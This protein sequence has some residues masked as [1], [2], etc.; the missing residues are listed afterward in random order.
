MRPDRLLVAV[1]AA[2]LLA[3][4]LPAVVPAASHAAETTEP[5][6]PLTVRLVRLTPAAIPAKGR[7]VMSGTVTNVS[8]EQWTAVN[9]HPFISRSPMTSRDQLAAAAASDPANEVGRRL[10]APGQFAAIGDIPPGAT[11]GFR[12]SLKVKDLPITGADG[13]Y[14]IGVHAL[15]QNTTGRDEVADGRART[16]IPLVSKAR[17]GTARTSVSVVVPIRERVR[18]DPDGRVLGLTQW[19]QNLAPSGRL[20]RLAGFLGSATSQQATALVDPAVLAAAKDLSGD[21]PALSFG[22]GKDPSSTPS[23]SATASASRSS[24]RLDPADRANAASWLAQVTASARTHTTLGLGYADPDVTALARRQ[25]S[26]L[27]LA[28]KIAATTFGEFDIPAVPTVAPPDGWLDDDLLTVIPT[29]SMLLVSDHAAPRTRTHWR[30][31]ENQDLVITDQQAASGGPSPGDGLDA[32]SLR[33]RIVSDAALRLSE[34]ADGPMVVELPADYDPGPSWQL[35]D[36]FNRLDLSWLDLVSLNPSSDSTTPTFDAA[37]GY[38]ASARKGE[39]RAPNVNATRTLLST[40]DVLTATLRSKN[41]VAHD[42]SGIAYDAV[43][44]NARNDQLQARS[45]VFATSARMRQT[46]G[47][48]EVIGTDFV[49]LSGGSG[50]LAVT[51]VNGL[52]Q[53]VTVGVKAT[54]PTGDVHIEETE[55]LKLAA[56]ERAVLRLKARASGVGVTPVVLSA[57]TADGTALGTPLTFSL[58]T[59]QVGNL[60]WG[61]LG[62]AALLLVVM[63]GLRIRRGLREHRWRRT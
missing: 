18:R 15:G 40:A 14:W 12:I 1:L 47:R 25:P 50:T 30:T 48:I 62:A 5:S 31:V 54:I 20:G 7:I 43:S 36:F 34:R 24:S 58:R 51:L 42:L 9:V 28:N 17:A 49:T 45:Q 55:P 26:L 60:I 33:Q 53:P 21:N 6:S 32:L 35:A 37:L 27:T 8:T 10:T 3:V 46:L 52:D 44:Y 57:V 19:A 63:I 22:D 39:I 29:E 11:T 61:V 4:L 16:F 59:S 56:G 13:V 41:A 23:P 2:L 38:P